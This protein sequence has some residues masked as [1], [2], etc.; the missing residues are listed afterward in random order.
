MNHESR[1]NSNHQKELVRKPIIELIKFPRESRS[2]SNFLATVLLPEL[3]QRIEKDHVR[4]VDFGC[5]RS[6]LAWLTSDSIDRKASNK[7]VDI[8]GYDPQ[9]DPED[10]VLKFWANNPSR[11]T[12][13]EFTNELP[14]AAD[15]VNCHFSLHHTEDL[16][17]T[18]Q[19]QIANQLSP[20]YLV[21]NEFDFVTRLSDREPAAQEEFIS[22]FKATQAG[23]AELEAFLSQAGGDED[24]AFAACYE[25][26]LKYSKQH[27]VDLLAKSGYMVTSE[28]VMPLS[29]RFDRYKF[30]IIAN[31]QSDRE[32]EN[33]MTSR[34]SE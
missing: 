30:L 31:K 11:R 20:Q 22:F 7:F 32:A 23:Q 13:I 17:A 25:F 1:T 21:I 29:F 3:T 12:H 2:L 24:K 33:L 15:I 27:Y 9:L 16:E 8:I 19:D 26:H 4:L 18:I 28:V 34:A 6:S 5:G 14:A 10:Q